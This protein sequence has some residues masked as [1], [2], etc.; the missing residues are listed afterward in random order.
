MCVYTGGL[1]AGASERVDVDVVDVADCDVTWPNTSPL[2]PKPTNHSRP[3]HLDVSR[4]HH[5]AEVHLSY[6]ADYTTTPASSNRFTRQPEIAC[7]H[8]SGA[9][10]KMMCR[11]VGHYRLV[12][13][14]WNQCSSFC[15]HSV[16]SPLRSITWYT[17]GPLYENTTSSAKP[18]IHGESQRH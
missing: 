18:E 3:R 13:F 5:V 17:A 6:T 9:Q 2:V 1:L 11:L 15:C 8:R 7:R 10:H 14:G 16:L 4:E 12:K